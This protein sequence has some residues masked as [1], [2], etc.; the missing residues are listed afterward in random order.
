MDI[1]L[2]EIYWSLQTLTVFRP[3]L[4]QPLLQQLVQYLQSAQELETHADDMATVTKTIS[5]YCD[6]TAE[7]YSSYDEKQ[8]E[9]SDNLTVYLY[10]HMMFCETDYLKACAYGK[11]SSALLQHRLTEELE[12]LQKVAQ[13]TPEVLQKPLRDAGYTMPLPSWTTCVL[14]FAKDY[15]ARI[16]HLP[17]TGFGL[18]ASYHTFLY[19]NGK[20]R[21]IKHPDTQILEDLTG[22]ERERRQVLRNTEVFLAGGTASNVLLY[23]DAGTG[24]STT[25]KAIANS[26]FPQGLRLIEVKKNEL[27]Q[28]PDLLDV[29]SGN[30]LKFI[31]FIDDLSFTGNDDNFSALKAI[32]EGGVASCG[33]N[34]LIYAT[35]NRRHLVKENMADRQGDALYLNDTLQETMSLAARFGLTITFQKP[36]KEDYLS[37]VKHLA[38]QYGVSMPEDELFTKAETYAIR[39]NGRSPRTAKHFIELQKSGIFEKNT[40]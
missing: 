8:T 18:F 12:I 23:G 34:V 1:Q 28:L 31:L 14:D 40:F 35:S 32:L 27:Y 36:D 26:F 11:T 5:A 30:P 38:I 6:F 19:T 21:P 16:Q 24:K 37:I 15:Q 2:K 25:V 29:L 17:K 39:C 20:I 7:I 22:Y 4:K 33:K 10:H 13:L 3:L 9:I